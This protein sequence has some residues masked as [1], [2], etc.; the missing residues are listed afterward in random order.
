[1][2]SQGQVANSILYCLTGFSLTCT[3]CNQLQ[4]RGGAAMAS[5]PLW[6]RAPLY[7]PHTPG[8]ALCMQHIPQFLTEMVHSCAVLGCTNKEECKGLKFYTLPKKNDSLPQIFPWQKCIPTQVPAP[9]MIPSDIVDH[10]HCYCSLDFQSPSIVLHPGSSYLTPI[11][12]SDIIPL[13]TPTCHRLTIDAATL[14]DLSIQPTSSFCIELFTNNNDAIQFYTGFESYNIMLISSFKFLGDDVNHLQYKD[15]STEPSTR[16]HS[17]ETRGA[18]RSLTPLN[19]FFLV[20]CRL[21]CA[22]LV[23]DIAYR[24]GVSR[25]TVCRIFT[26]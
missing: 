22:L 21:R 6:F 3:L 13:Q 10:N 24:F 4:R 18:P 23:N 14:T 17:E 9:A 12:A 25:A 26:T 19:E 7:L 11:L 15:T 16:V 20:L 5:L 1:M 8:Y 2:A